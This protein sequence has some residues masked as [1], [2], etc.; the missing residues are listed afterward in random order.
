VPG[1]GLVIEGVMS[2]AAVEDADQPVA[3]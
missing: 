3:A 1:S 2:Q